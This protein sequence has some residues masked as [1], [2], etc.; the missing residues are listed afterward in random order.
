[1]EM[2][3][4]LAALVRRVKDVE[5]AVKAAED[6]LA[7]NKAQLRELTEVELPDVMAEV[8]IT[9]MTLDDG[10]VVTIKEAVQA[11]ITEA[12]KQAAFQWLVQHGFGSIIKTAVS[13]EFNAGHRDDAVELANE[14]AARQTEVRLDEKV[15]PQTL[16]AFVRERLAAGDEV[17]MDLF[18]VFPRNVAKIRSAK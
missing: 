14:L 2:K 13:V 7:F 9:E 8:G 17:P 3:E 1:M 12:N 6:E 11:A 18:S 16:K 5:R 4:R 10:T 15:H